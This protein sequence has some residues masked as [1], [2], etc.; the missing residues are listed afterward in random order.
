MKKKL[1]VAVLCFA[2]AVAIALFFTTKPKRKARKYI[3]VKGD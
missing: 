3:T 2:T 1:F